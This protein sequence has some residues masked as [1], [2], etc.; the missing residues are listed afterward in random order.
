[1]SNVETGQQMYERCNRGDILG[2]RAWGEGLPAVL[3]HGALAAG[4]ENWEAQR[5]LAEEG[6]RLVVPDRRGYADG[7][8]ARG[9]DFLR[10]A[11]D[12]AELLGDGAH[13]V[14][15]SYGGIGA[16]L[17]AARRPDAVLSL[18]VIEPPAFGLCR[19]NPAVAELLADMERLWNREDLDDR[20]FLEE[21]LEMVGAS[22]DEVPEEMLDVWTGRVPL[23]RSEYHR[24][25]VEADIPLARL[26]SAPFP[27]LVV[28]GGHHP[29]F[30][31]V[32]DELTSALG[33]ERV[34]IT[35]A[36]HEVYMV[37]EPFNEALLGLWRNA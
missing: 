10:D 9:E 30:D 35:G 36:G 12:V 28:S 8:A 11:G 34:V 20:G 21:F 15:H 24:K 33:A 19:D 16:L 26:A 5:P 27:K 32:C 23:M 7:S 25:P 22:P 13:L 18:T 37:A 4:E 29:A 3:V 2:G 17:A 31:A 1:M 6:F 14:G